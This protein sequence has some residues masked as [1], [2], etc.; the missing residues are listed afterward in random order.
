VK[1][2]K[3]RM[4]KVVKNIYIFFLLQALKSFSHSPWLSALYVMPLFNQNSMLSCKMDLVCSNYIT[5]STLC[6]IRNNW[7]GK[8]LT[9]KALKLK[10]QKVHASKSH[11]TFYCF[12]LSLTY[13]K[14]LRIFY[15]KLFQSFKL[16]CE[17]KS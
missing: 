16:E 10:E 13:N 14:I 8:T 15:L 4:K 11:P 3:E 12:L 7:W 17:E 6:Q 1:P 2:V 9:T 5:M